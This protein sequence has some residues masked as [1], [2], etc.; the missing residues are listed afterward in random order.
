M[1]LLYSFSLP[2]MHSTDGATTRGLK[3]TLPKT[4]K[5]FLGDFGFYTI[6]T[7]GAAKALY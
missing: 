2:S 7:S 3:Q 1:R 6:T 4:G 5:N